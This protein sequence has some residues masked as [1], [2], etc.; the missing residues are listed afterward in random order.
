[1]ICDHCARP[2]ER[3]NEEAPQ[4]VRMNNVRLYQKKMVSQQ[5]GCFPK[6]S[7][8]SCCRRDR[9]LYQTNLTVVCSAAI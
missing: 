1:M 2:G 4:T 7:K 5:S 3:R 6:Q 8:L 9:Q